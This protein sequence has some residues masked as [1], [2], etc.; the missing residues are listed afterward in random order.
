MPEVLLYECFSG[1]SGDMH[2]GA[3]L[4]LGVPEEHLRNEL[5][6]LGLDDEFGLHVG[7]SKKNGI[8]GTAVK[9]ELRDQ[10]TPS[11]KLPDITQ[12]ILG[13][14]LSDIAADR[15]VETF[16]LL[17]RAEAKVHAIPVDEVHFHEVGAVDAIVDIAGAAIS[18]EYLHPDAVYCSNVELGSGL[19]QC[20]HGLMP[21]PAP[22]TALILEDRPTTRGNVNGEATTP[23]GAAILA[24]AVTHWQSPPQLK[25]ISTAYGVGQKD[26]E[27]PNVLRVSLS[28]VPQNLEY[29]TNVCI[30]TN[31]DDMSP[32]AFEPLMVELLELGA[33]DV[34]NTP[35]IMKKS[36]PGI[37]LSVL[38]ES[39]D[40]DALIQ[41]I[42]NHS[43]SIGVRSYSVEK[44]M[45]PRRME[46]VVTSLG[47]VSVK[48]VDT[49]SG[50]Q[51]WKVEH[52][53]VQAAATR[54]NLSY[55]EAKQQIEQ[56]VQT[57]IGQHGKS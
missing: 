39:R 25:T 50:S 40:S 23:T 43:T 3:M 34:Y 47:E 31:I 14:G 2:L 20:A 29:E 27:R 46:S 33:R 26:F 11:R 52:D 18:L 53:D 49:P 41:C 55:L 28:S 15:A 17:A 56:Q 16:E 1:I 22:A 4:D 8:A 10:S 7:H 12:L 51:R 36:R 42:L 13:S 44:T 57:V 45:L 19:V 38:A 32:E 54:A 21:V 6:K 9:V 5:S 37:K 35:I 24:G 48:I 30:E